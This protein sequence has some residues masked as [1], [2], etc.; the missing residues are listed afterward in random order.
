MEGL[1]LVLL[2]LVGIVVYFIPTI[3][4]FVRN[5]SNKGAIFCMNF[6]LGWI[7]IGWVVGLIWAVS[8][9]KHA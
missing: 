7:F 8:E 6:F 4:A 5:R 3:I 9:E 1:L 2:V